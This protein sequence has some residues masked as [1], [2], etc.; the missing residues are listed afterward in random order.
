MLHTYIIINY[1]GVYIHIVAINIPCLSA[2]DI[3]HYRIIMKTYAFLEKIDNVSMCQCII[4]ILLSF[5]CKTTRDSQIK[6]DTSQLTLNRNNKKVTLMSSMKTVA[7]PVHVRL[8]ERS[9][10]VVHALL[11]HSVVQSLEA[12][13]S[14]TLNGCL[15]LLVIDAPAQL[16]MAHCLV[17]GPVLGHH[18]HVGVRAYNVNNTV[19]TLLHWIAGDTS[20]VSIIIIY[21]LIMVVSNTRTI[22]CIVW[23]DRIWH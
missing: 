6:A 3:L 4:M 16:L 17:L 9:E 20:I 2:L 19:N 5:Q 14:E 7:L 1:S 22:S 23:P 10:F 21:T 18:I 12:T 11:L 8:E 15:H 13:L